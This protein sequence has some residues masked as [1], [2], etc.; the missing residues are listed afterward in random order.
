MS[1]AFTD[2]EVSGYRTLIPAMT[3][4]EKDRHVLAAA[5]RANVEALVTFNLRDFPGA[6]VDP[7][8]IRVV[9]PD[10]FLLDQVDLHPQQTRAALERQASAYKHDPMSFDDLLDALDRAGVPDFAKSLRTTT[11]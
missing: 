4:D 7:Y 10:D 9:H 3:C 5:V 11:R 8:D 1:R 2:A 6:A